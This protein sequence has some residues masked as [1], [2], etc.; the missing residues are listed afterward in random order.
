MIMLLFDYP[1]K[2]RLNRFFPKMAI[3]EKAF[4]QQLTNEIIPQIPFA[5]KSCKLLKLAKSE[6]S[7]LGGVGEPQNIVNADV[8]INAELYRRFRGNFP[9]ARFVAA[10]AR[11][12]AA[13][14]VRHLFLSCPTAFSQRLYYAGG[15]FGKRSFGIMGAIGTGRVGALIGRAPQQKIRTDI[16]IGCKYHQPFQRNAAAAVFIAYV[17]D[18]GAAQK[19]GDL[20]LC[21][22]SV[23]SHDFECVFGFH[24]G[25]RLSLG[26]EVPIKSFGYGR[27]LFPRR[28]LIGKSFFIDSFRRFYHNIRRLSKNVE[29]G[30]MILEN[31]N[32]CLLLPKYFVSFVDNAGC[33]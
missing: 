3:A 9:L 18:T 19:L 1:R 6:I 2:H 25:F 15:G 21:V 26:S 7:F 22:G 30:R 4:N 29:T 20:L 33:M 12:G 8:V 17:A 14:E 27:R 24:F 16:V 10:V 32:S 13:E 28:S 11:L 31:V 23:H 5:V